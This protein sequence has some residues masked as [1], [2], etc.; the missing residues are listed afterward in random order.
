MASNGSPQTTVP[1]PAEMRPG[2]RCSLLQST[3]E[4]A[5]EIGTTLE[6][7]TVAE[8]L[9][10]R[11]KI[12]YWHFMPMEIQLRILS[13]LTPKELGR[14]ASVSKLW[15]R[16]CF[17]GQLW[18]NFDASTYYSDIPRD[19]LERLIFSA[20]SFIKHL[21][22]RGCIQMQEAWLE[23]GEQIADAC[24][25][26]ASV[27]LADTHIDKL[28]VTFFL[29]RN[30]GLVRIN[31]NGLPTVT[32]SEINVIAKNC[33]LLEHLDVSWCR[34]LISAKGLRRVVR[35]CPRLKELRIGE[36][37]AVDN[38][39]FMQQLFETN[40]LETLVMSHCSSLTDD[41]LKVLLYGTDPEIDILSGRPVVPP[42]K[43]KHLDLSRCGSLTDAGIGHLTGSVPDL[44]SL[45]LS[46]CHALGSDTITALIRTTPR[47][48][49][50]D[51]EELEEI[52]NSVLIAISKARCASSMEHLN[53][54]Y[55][56]RLGDSG[57]MQLIKHCPNL[58][59]LDL[60]NTRVSDLTLMELCTQ[61]RKRGY[62]TTQPKYGL[63]LAVFDCGNVTWAGV[64]EV[65]CNNTHVP[66]SAEAD[67]ATKA[68][69]NDSSSPSSSTSSIHTVLPTPP[70]AKTTA[71][72]KPDLYP[73][74]II[75]L[76][77]FYGWQRTVD[78]HTKRVL[79]GNLGAAMRL[80][81]KW[82]D[83]MVANEEAEA[84]AGAGGLGIGIGMGMGA[85]RRRRRRAREAVMV[86]NADGDDDDDD[87]IHENGDDNEDEEDDEDAEY[88]YGYGPAGLASLGTRRRR[89]RSGGCVV[90]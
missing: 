16:L 56:E 1:L 52:T 42:R 17:D 44:E 76:K 3:A 30:S 74:E 71:Q 61:M 19:A 60:D 57:M 36:F 15:Y 12:D 63:R 89:A 84:G 23:N 40:T 24:R 70:P 9:H 80:E 35:A 73:T 58:K 75:H 29:V 2:S 49:R 53:V 64:R 38:L 18:S 83:C 39:D 41:S 69:E 62:G 55:C 48:A 59:S 85:R 32:N 45:Q 81:R 43:L 31:V 66:R 72:S 21:N 5:K 77:C 10:E 20:G 37:Q 8:I 65:L 33:P 51:L 54:S 86:Y 88:G 50:L 47:L 78:R 46:F 22:L 6:E 26:L 14:A 79:D 4:A 82:A 68:E 90:M 28:T 25:N 13:W 34:N 27:N 87:D 67:T 7:N 11:R